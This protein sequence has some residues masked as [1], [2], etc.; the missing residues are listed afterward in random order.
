MPA[1]QNAP[2]GSARGFFSAIH[3]E[4][5]SC[6]REATLESIFAKLC[7]WCQDAAVLYF[8]TDPNTA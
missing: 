2:S 6:K 3:I 8:V 4:G 1:P 5:D 7:A